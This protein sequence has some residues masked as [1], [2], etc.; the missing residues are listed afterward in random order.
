MRL[1]IRPWVTCIANH[2]PASSCTSDIADCGMSRLNFNREVRLLDCGI[3]AAIWLSSV[4]QRVLAWRYHGICRPAD[5]PK[6]QPYNSSAHLER[7]LSVFVG[8][9]QGCKPQGMA[10]ELEHKGSGLHLHI[11]VEVLKDGRHL[12]SSRQ[13]QYIGF[14]RENL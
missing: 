11:V 12:S 8:K 13:C 9:R 14:I 1:D 6:P 10:L 2:K 5:C 7:R 4:R 3:A